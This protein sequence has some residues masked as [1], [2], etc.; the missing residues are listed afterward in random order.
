MSLSISSCSLNSKGKGISELEETPLS[1]KNQKYGEVPMLNLTESYDILMKF[2]DKYPVGVRL[3][4]DYILIKTAKSDTCVFVYDK[5][6]LSQIW[7]TG[8][9]GNGSEDV[10]NPTFFASVNPDSLGRFQMADVSDNS[11][12]YID[13]KEKTLTKSKLPQYIGYSSSINFFDKYCVAAKNSEECMFYIHNKEKKETLPILFDVKLGENIK[14]KIGPNI[15]YMLSAITYASENKNRIIVPHYFFDMYSIYDFS[16]KFLR[17]I[18][19]SSNNYDEQKAAE[20][21][22]NNEGYI[23]YSPSFATSDACYLSRKAFKSPQGEAEYMQI[24]KTNWEGEPLIIYNLTS[25]LIGEFCIDEE[26]LY[27]ICKIIDEND[28]TYLLLRWNLQIVEK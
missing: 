14:S 17:K 18:S 19:L 7:R 16:G 22:L 27:G 23:G 20:N 28:E 26:Y 21:L 25:P 9:N 5:N 24:I 3:F 15:S 2:Q 1:I 6:T 13:I 10:L 8:V 11:H 4:K 12:V